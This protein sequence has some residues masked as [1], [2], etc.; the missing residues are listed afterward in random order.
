M[1]KRMVIMLVVVGVVLSGLFGFQAF[2][3]YKQSMSSQGLPP[4]TVSTTQ[5]SYQEW[6]PQLEAVGSLRAVRGADLSPE[7]AGIVSDIHFQQGEDVKAGTLLLELRANDDSAKLE[8]LK[9]AAELARITYERDKAQFQAKAVSQQTLDTSAANLKQATANVAEQQALVDKKFIRAPFSGRLGIRAVDLGQYLN[10]GTLIVTLQALDPIYVDFYLP[11]QTLGVIKVG[12][13]VT[14][15]TDA[16]PNQSF[17]GEIAVINPEVDLN[18]RNVQV[19]A[20]LKNPDHKLLPGMYA[21]VDIASGRPQ[22]YLTLPQ[23]AITYNPYGATVFLVEVKGKD[24]QG[25]PLLVARQSFVT[26]GETRGDQVAVTQGVKEG[27]TVVTAG[28]TKLRNGM[29][30]VIN[31]S[32]QPSD[33]PAPQPKD[34]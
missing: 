26:T 27:D 31:N 19:R 28:Q 22:R 9:A 13:Q 21:S 15:R 23:T 10:A 11:Q 7:V 12:Q 6:Q 32:I 4:P 34:E 2:K 25:K 29:P 14:A 24:N 1:A 8:S 33:N 18:T 17:V 20:M 3:A 5:A 16:Y 30:I